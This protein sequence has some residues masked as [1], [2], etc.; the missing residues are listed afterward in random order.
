MERSDATI[1]QI[2]SRIISFPQFLI[3]PRA[4]FKVFS[5]DGVSMNQLE[6]RLPINS[7]RAVWLSKHRQ[8]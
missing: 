6:P 4:S 2:R 8:I 3:F 5:C 7:A 1:Q